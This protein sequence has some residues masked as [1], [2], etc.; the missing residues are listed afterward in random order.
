MS[1]NEGRKAVIEGLVAVDYCEG[2]IENWSPAPHGGDLWVFG[3]H[4]KG[5]P[6]YIKMQI[7][8][9]NKSAICVSF[10]PAEHKLLFPF[11]R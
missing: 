5:E 6:Y 11:K 8:H 4:I 3:K 1:P 9:T 10:H 7:G 2:P